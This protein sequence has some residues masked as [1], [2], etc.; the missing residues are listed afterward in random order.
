[1]TE[2]TLPERAVEAAYHLAKK[3]LTE[4]ELKAKTV[5][6]KNTVIMFLLIILMVFASWGWLLY[7]QTQEQLASANIQLAI[8]K[9]PEEFVKLKMFTI[10]N[11]V[12]IVGTEA[13]YPRESSELARDIKALTIKVNELKQV[14]DAALEKANAHER[15]LKKIV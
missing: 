10:N 9:S 11:V 6:L 1:M 12:Y 5:S 14:A 8:K 7:I 13:E 2:H 15:A 4:N 3:P